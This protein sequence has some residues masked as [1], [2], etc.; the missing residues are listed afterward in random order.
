MSHSNPST[1][2][3]FKSVLASFFGV[4]SEENR[5]RDFEHGSPGQFIVIGLVLTVIF[6]VV[7]YL[8]VKLILL[9]AL[10]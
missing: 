5:R 4:Q 1:W 10:K 6:I 9:L 7:L 3:V 2:Q 8:L